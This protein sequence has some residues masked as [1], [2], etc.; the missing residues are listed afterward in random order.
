M[1]MASVDYMSDFLPIKRSL[2]R[3]NVH[4]DG[5]QDSK[6]SYVCNAERALR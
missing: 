1:L 4:W 3:A 2:R 5:Q 6:D